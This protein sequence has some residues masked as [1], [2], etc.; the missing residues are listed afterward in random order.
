MAKRKVQ[1]TRKVKKVRK[2]K[3]QRKSLDEIHY[4]PEPDVDYF[5]NHSIHDFFNWYNYMSAMKAP[6]VHCICLYNN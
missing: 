2:T 6:W 5:N 4:G 3:A 1:S